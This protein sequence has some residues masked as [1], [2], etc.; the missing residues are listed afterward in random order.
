MQQP[1]RALDYYR[2]NIVDI[3][4]HTNTSHSGKYILPE[5]HLFLYSGGDDGKRSEV[6]GIAIEKGV[7]GSLIT[8][9]PYSSRIMTACFHSKQVT[10]KVVVAHATIEV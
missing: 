3:T 5:G 9:V 7:R 8:F 2:L 4:E 6:V 10:L 1:V